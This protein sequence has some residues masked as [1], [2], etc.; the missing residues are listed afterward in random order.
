[1]VLVKYGGTLENF[2][3]F[4]FIFPV[5]FT[6]IYQSLKDDYQF[7]QDVRSEHFCYCTTIEG[8]NDAMKDTRLE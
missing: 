1:M 4:S 6:Y 3:G 5:F 2:M 7:N 8:W